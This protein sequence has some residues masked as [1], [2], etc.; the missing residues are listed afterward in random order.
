MV[1]VDNTFVKEV[2]KHNMTNPL[3]ILN[4][5]QNL[6]HCEDNHTEQGIMTYAIN[7]LFVKYK[8]II[9]IIH[10]KNCRYG[11]PLDRTKPPFKYYK[12][13]CIMCT[14]EDVVGD[15]PMVYLPTHYCSYGEER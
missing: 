15:E 11:K 13:G 4:W 12:D 8:D 2:K 9:S 5:Y 6:Y 7:G 14:C 3:D 1:L 10:C